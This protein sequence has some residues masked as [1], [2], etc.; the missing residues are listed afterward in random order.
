MTM[1]ELTNRFAIPGVA[2]FEAGLGHLTRIAV[3]AP[4]GQAH[5]YLHGGHVAHWHPAD[6]RQPVLWMSRH[7]RAAPDAPL[8]GGVPIC[9]PWFADDCPQ[10]DAPLHGFA[11]TMPWR[12]ES[13]QLTPRKDVVVTLSLTADDQ[14][15][16]HW[17]GGFELTYTVTVGAALT[18]ALAVRNVGP[19]GKPFR[20]TE[21]LHS[22]FRISGI[23]DIAVTG[24]ARAEY[25]DKVDARRRKRQGDEPLRFTGET[26]RIYVNTQAACVLKD[27]GLERQITVAKS[28][29]NSTVVW[30]PWHDKAARMPDFG[31]N[32]WPFMACIETANAAE[33]AVTVAPG[34]SHVLQAE[35]SVSDLD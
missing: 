33:N 27:Y 10:A 29:S 21:A 2:T 20:I 35:I 17:P 13:V 15:R 23:K 31:D 1:D 9:F 7:T 19:S 34:E 12:L 16:R 30:N 5:V 8:R 3:T 6:Q 28:G 26:D 25:I 4:R 18:M 24:L 14:T 22:Y 32:E 11:R